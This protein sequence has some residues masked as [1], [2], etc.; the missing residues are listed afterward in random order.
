MIDPESG[1]PHALS[2]DEAKQELE[3][4]ARELAEHD[5]RYHQEDA[6]LIADA[7]YDALRR[8]FEG[9]A[10]RYPDLASVSALLRSVGAAPAERFGKV[11]HRQPMLSLDNGFSDADVADFLRSVRRFLR[12]PEEANLAL[13]AE[14]KIDGLSA[15]LR[16]VDGRLVQGA[17]RGDGREGEDVTAN[18]RTLPDVPLHLP[19]A[20]QVLEVRGEVYMERAAFAA[21]NA[22]LASEGAQTYVNPRNAAAGSLRQLDP[23]ISAARPLRFFAH[24][25]GEV[26]EPLTETQSGAMARLAALGFAVNPLL[27]VCTSLEELL[28]A[29]RQIGAARAGLDYEIDGVVYKIDSLALQQRLGFASRSPRWALAHKYAPEQAQ[30][31]LE[32]IDIQ[33]GRT[34][35]LTPVAKLRPVFVGGVTVANATLHNEDEIRRKDVRVGD[36][37]IVQRAGD[38]IPQVV[39]PVLDRRPPEAEPFEFPAAC[40]ACG[41]QAEREADPESGELDAVRRCTAGL[42]CPAQAVERLKHFVSRRALDIEGLGEKQIEAFYAEGVVRSPAEIFTLSERVHSGAID[43]LGREGYGATSV[44][45]LLAAIE[46][47]RTPGLERFVFALGIRHVGE[48]IAQM[49]ARHYGEWES[50]RA[51]G[52]AAAAGDEAALAELSAVERIGPI[53][54]AAICRFFAEPQNRDVL[55]QLRAA[56]VAPLPAERPSADSAIA[57]KTVVFT[58]SLERMTRDEAKAR[59]SAL[60]AKVS[61]SIS[62]KTDLVI[63]GPGAGSKLKEAQA[64]GVAV[65][66]EED[67]IQLIGGDQGAV[68]SK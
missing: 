36:T 18:L 38:V 66:S 46:A 2:A 29:Y 54:A 16:Y 23:A 44:A 20:P 32:G 56:G 10:A 60:G 59:A 24:G 21:M 7:E 65:I 17:T 4:L 30:T 34:G 12:V 9:L 64:L 25:W 53:K 11:Q 19:G 43:L 31:L 49:L 39:G 51:A 45:N 48:T 1:A 58:G 67:W 40:P 63:A 41:A 13:T 61:G 37:V 55:D 50:L 33:V 14:P 57:G 5:R 47:R 35:S 62:R 8:R 68:S 28:Q 52:E 15:S 26:S 42:A 27:R 3:R 22:R 6:P